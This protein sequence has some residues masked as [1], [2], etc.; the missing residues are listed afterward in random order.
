MLPSSP[1]VREVYLGSA[2]LLQSVQPGSL[3][4]D[5]STIGPAT[6]REV[7]AAAAAKQAIAADAP[8]SGGA[9]ALAVARGPWPWRTRH[10]EV[11]W[12]VSGPN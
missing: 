10:A 9:W 12:A 8:V 4:I 3:L 2:G 11:A 1:H 6:A 5:C 7:A